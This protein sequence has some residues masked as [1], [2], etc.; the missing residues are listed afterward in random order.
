M[1]N[2]NIKKNKRNQGFTIIETVVSV[3]I[4]AVI[5]ISLLNLFNVILKNI[6]NNRAILSANSIV[7]EQLETIRGMDFD[8]IKT[9]TGWVPA[10]PIVGV[11]SFNRAGIEFTVRTDISWADDAYDGLDPVDSFPYDYKKV[12]VR[13]SWVNP[14]NGSVE[15]ISMSTTAVPVGIEGLSEDKGGLY[16]TVF[17]A[18]GLPVYDADVKVSSTTLG[19]SL[20]NAKTDVNGNLWLPDLDPANDYHIEATKPGYSV[21]QTYAINNDPLSEDYNP[22]PEKNDAIVIAQKVGKFGFAIDALGSMLIR[23]V[24]FSNPANVVVNADVFGEQNNPSV[25]IYSDD[26]YV[27]WE[28]GR[29]GGHDI[30]MQKFVYSPSSGT[31]IRSWSADV[32]LKDNAVCK[33]PKLE[34]SDNGFLYLAWRDERDGDSDI[35]LQGISTSDGSLIGTEYKVNNDSIPYSQENPSIDSD[36]AGNLYVVWEDNRGGSWD[37]YGQ[38]FDFISSG[39]WAS[40]LKINSTDTTEQLSPRIILDRDTGGGGENMNNFY[41]IWQ[42]NDSGDF[43]IMLRKFDLNGTEVFAERMINNDAAFLDQ[44]NPAITFD[45]SEY[46]YAVWS[47]DRNSQPDIYMQKINKSGVISFAEDKK[48]N[49]DAFAE[50]RRFNPSVFYES[51]SAIYVAWEDSRNGDAYYNIYTAKLDS[52][53]NKLWEYDLVLADTLESVQLSPFLSV[54]S[55]GRAVTIWE[56]NRSGDNDI[57]FAVYDDLGSITNANIPIRVISTKIKGSYQNPIEGEMPE[58][59]PIPKYSESFMSDAAGNIVIDSVDGGLEWGS[60]YFETESTYSIKSIDLPSPIS[61]LP[62]EEA[63]VVINIEN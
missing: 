54:D 47:D 44:Y 5:S 61:V 7:L 30:Y 32:M 28:D 17:D 21:S 55:R 34:V 1:Q 56:D 24:H 31:Y 26:A 42:S 48:I 38:K 53:V 63:N 19:Y 6:R 11:K 25:A 3:A 10:G 2:K 59:I 46:F 16:I 40:D 50:A 18:E 14:I 58:F 37:I 33:S 22:V 12:R 62:G 8:N 36:Q 39:F 15:E 27:V 9:D 49:D 29:N 4:F 13:I 23:T 45:G 60:Y 41:V 57:Y 43:D 35:Y 51:D 52:S 20:E